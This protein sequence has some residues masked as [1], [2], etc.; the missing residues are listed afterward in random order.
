MTTV[1]TASA[2]YNFQYIPDAGPVVSLKTVTDQVQPE[3][4]ITVRGKILK[5]DRVEMVGK[6]NLKTLRK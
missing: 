3:V 4:L 6:N 5:G 1:E 2:E